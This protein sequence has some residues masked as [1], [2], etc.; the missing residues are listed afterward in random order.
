M[1]EKSDVIYFSSKEALIKI[2]VLILTIGISVLASMVDY[3]S[4]YVAVMVQAINNVYDFYQFTDNKRYVVM[5]KRESIAIIF[6]AIAASIISVIA[7]TRLY[8]FTQWILVKLLVI[9]M[10][11]LPIIVVYNDYRINIKKEND[12]EVT[13]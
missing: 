11:T 9:F 10:V 3:Q 4:C 13:I 8:E 12:S 7:L 1:G 2:F 5:V 6:F